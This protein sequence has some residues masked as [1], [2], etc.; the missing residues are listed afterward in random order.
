MILYNLISLFSQPIFWLVMLIIWFQFR[1][2]AKMKSEFF[3]VPEE[4]VLQPTLIATIY[5]VIGGILGSFILVFVG[6]SVLE[7]G[8]QYLWMLAIIFMLIDRRFMCFAYAGGMV[9]IIKYF[10]GYPDISIPQVMGL[11][12]ILHLVEAVLILFSGHL[13]AVPIYVKGKDGRPIGGFNLQKF[14]PLPIVAMVAVAMPETNAITEVMKMPDWWPLIKPE[15]LNKNE[16]IVY[17]LV[18][19]IAGLGYG[20]IALTTRPR[21][22]TSRSALHLAIFSIIL[23]GLAILGANYPSLAI[24]AAVFAPLGHEVIIFLGRRFEF[25]GE[26]KYVSPEQGIM[27]LDLLASSPLNSAGLIT[28]DIILNINGVPLNNSS[29]LEYAL[30][31][32]GSS[33]EVEFLS[34]DNKIF[35]RKIIRVQRPGKL[36]LIIVPDSFG[37]SYLEVSKGES[38][39]KKIFKWFKKS[40]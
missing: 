31:F 4:S 15:L 12:A 9:S 21:E 13:G 14:W 11:V 28:G 25:A 29:D 22:K 38:L 18:P 40:P 6:I 34:G 2:M 3:N 36:G 1:R 24:M 37:H 16:N 7:V 26:P 33:F 32:A 20:D 27:V 30:Q 8:I 17:M 39:F 23:L 35:K 19:V 10:F 5:G